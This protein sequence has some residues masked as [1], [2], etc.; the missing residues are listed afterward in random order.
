[1]LIELANAL[2]AHTETETGCRFDLT[3]REYLNLLTVLKVAL[4]LGPDRP[5]TQERWSHHL[6]TQ[7]RKLEHLKASIRQI[8]DEL[9]ADEQECLSSRPQ[10]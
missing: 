1:M 5:S 2:T 3:Q 7:R 6:A 10:G 8:E 9:A 4:K